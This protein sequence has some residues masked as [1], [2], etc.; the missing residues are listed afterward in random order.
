MTGMNS[1]ISLIGRLAL[2]VSAFSLLLSPALGNESRTWTAANGKSTMTGVATKYT[3]TEVTIS[4]EA[5]KTLKVKTSQLSEDDRAWLEANQKNSDKADGAAPEAP[6]G[7]MSTV[8]SQFKGTT[9]TIARNGK[10]K[11]E[12]IK[13]NAK[14]YLILFS[15]SWCGPCC[16]EMPLIVREYNRKIKNNPNLEL[17][18]K[19]ADK[20]L[21]DALD[22]GKQEKI[23]FPTVLPGTNC[24]AAVLGLRQ[25]GGIPRLLVVTASGEKVAED[26]PARLL[27]SYQKEIEKYE[28]AKGGKSG[29][30]A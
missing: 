13:P 24:N 19:S 1:S 12:D 30:Q 9:S 10:A 20:T 23:P 29:G 25:G 6:S 15:A 18:H 8:A 7:E 27:K 17:V 22:W 5:G 26:H 16:A 3:G 14:Y 11:K 4:T 21:E 28:E 2:I